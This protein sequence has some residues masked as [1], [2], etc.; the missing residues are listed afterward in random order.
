MIIGSYLPSSSKLSLKR[1][2]HQTFAP[3]WPISLCGDVNHRRSTPETDRGQA[4]FSRIDCI[5]NEKDMCSLC[6]KLICEECAEYQEL[7]L[8]DICEVL[9]C[10]DCSEDDLEKCFICCSS[11]CRECAPGCEETVDDMSLC[12]QCAEMR[13]EEVYDYL[14]EVEQDYGVEEETVWDYWYEEG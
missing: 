2:N 14:Y 6:R 11:Y 12:R 4:G 3:D 5:C 13:T 10:K 9:L 8:C 1:V 7:V